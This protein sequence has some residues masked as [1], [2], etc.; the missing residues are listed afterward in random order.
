MCSNFTLHT[1]DGTQ[2]NH[3]PPKQEWLKTCICKHKGAWTEHRRVLPSATSLLM[4]M[5]EA[6]QNTYHKANM[7][8]SPEKLGLEKVPKRIGPCRCRRRW[9]R[10]VKHVGHGIQSSHKQSHIGQSG[11]SKLVSLSVR[12]VTRFACLALLGTAAHDLELLPKLMKPPC[13]LIAWIESHDP[14]VKEVRFTHLLPL[15][16]NLCLRFSVFFE[17]FILFYFFYPL[18]FPPLTVKWT[19]YKPE[20]DSDW[21]DLCVLLR[22]HA[23]FFVSWR[24]AF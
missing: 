24:S 15:Q 1:S 2:W 21:A 14:D 10:A 11:Y 13:M 6:T 22:F 17:T 5:W 19:L 20:S 23:D 8:Y 9:R 3:S 7:G 4:S 18:V 16:R 12:G